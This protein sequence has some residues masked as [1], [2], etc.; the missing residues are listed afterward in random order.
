M[1]EITQMSFDKGTDS[2][3]DVVFTESN[4]TKSSEDVW[5]SCLQKYGCILKYNLE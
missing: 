3:N 2:I 1:L 5:N 4:I